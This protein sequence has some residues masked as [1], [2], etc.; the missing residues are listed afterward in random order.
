MLTLSRAWKREQSGRCTPSPARGLR[1]FSVLVHTLEA[2]DAWVSTWRQRFKGQPTAL[3]LELNKGPL[4]SALRKYDFLVFFPVN[5]LMLARYREAFAPS[6]AKDDPPDAELQLDL[7]RKHR[8]KLTPLK[9]QSPAM[10]TLE[11]AWRRH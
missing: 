4:V 6:H 1:E 3:R 9:P 5:P 10:R 2:I 11:Q 8:E 7:L